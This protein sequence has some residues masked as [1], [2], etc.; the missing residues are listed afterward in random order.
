MRGTLRFLRRFHVYHFNYSRYSGQALTHNLISRLRQERHIA[1]LYWHPAMRL[2]LHISAQLRRTVSNLVRVRGFEPPTNGLKVRCSTNWATRALWLG[3]K[4]SNLCI[5]GQSR[6]HWPLC[7]API[8]W[9]FYLTTSA[10]PCQENCFLKRK[11]WSWRQDSN[12]Q[13]PDYKSDAL[14]IA[15]RQHVMVRPIGLEPMTIR[16]WG[17][18]SHQLNY[19]HIVALLTIFIVA[20]WFFFVSKNFLDFGF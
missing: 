17:G 9:W 19:G 8:I 13:P 12:L 6:A 1:A 3:R 10:K 18:G 14:P 20:D 7:Y 11:K 2:A 4:E 5:S 15:P 16:L